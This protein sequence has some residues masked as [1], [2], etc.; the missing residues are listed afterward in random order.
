[1]HEQLHVQERYLRRRLPLIIVFQ[2]VAKLERDDKKVVKKL[3]LA[4]W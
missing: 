2:K 1:M 3:F 4:N